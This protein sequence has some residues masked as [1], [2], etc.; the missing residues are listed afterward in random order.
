MTIMLRVLAL[1]LVANTVV[2][3]QSA[4]RDSASGSASEQ[5][6]A[7]YETAVEMAG[8]LHDP[9]LMGKSYYKLAAKYLELNKIDK[10]IDAYERSEQ[11]FKEAGLLRDLIYIYGDLGALF[12]NQ[13]NFR[14][15]REYSEES[16]QR[17]TQQRISIS[18]PELGPMILVGRGLYILSPKLTCAK[19]TTL[20]QSTSFKDH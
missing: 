17:P 19:E 12:F 13:E 6:L 8:Q 11:C 20:T 7:I 1:I 15:A 16:I 14:K 4:G 5:S 18:L 2:W 9:K 10:A 3:A